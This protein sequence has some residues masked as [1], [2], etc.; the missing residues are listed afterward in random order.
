MITA[1][2]STAN[3]VANFETTYALTVSW[4]GCT[5]ANELSHLRHDL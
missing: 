5:D 1:D 3:F 4:F 2:P